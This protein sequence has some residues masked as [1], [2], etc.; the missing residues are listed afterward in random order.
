[1]SKLDFRVGVVFPQTD[2]ENDPIVIRDFAQA[3]EGMGFSSINAYDHILGADPAGRSDRTF[4][5]D[6]ESDFQ[7]P[8]MLF[9]F[10]AGH[11]TRIEL[12]TAVINLPQ[13]QTALFAKQAA[14]LDAYCGGRL[15]L[16]IGIGANPVEY[17]ALGV[18]YAAR[19]KR[20]DDQ[21]VLL[22]RYWTEPTLSYSSPFHEVDQAG[23]SPLPL[24]RPIP[25]WIGGYSPAAMNRAARLGDG[26]MPT[27][28]AAV[29]SERLDQFHAA[30]ADAGRGPRDVGF[31]NHILLGNALGGP[32]RTIDDA[33]ADVEIW[34]KA[35]APG[36]FIST[37]GR[38]MRGADAHLAMFRRIAEDLA[39]T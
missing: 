31:E 37:L 36:V 12:S 32:V 28:P 2:I 38:G 1:M 3:V 7:E 24:Q 21:I 39:L 25:L 6:H 35:G 23:I 4:P 16:G 13:R 34:R 20:L 19:G 10:L 17:Q 26:W 9:A 11:T 18:D 8:L 27:L 14:N 30:L 22:R 15:R 5:F 33:V 29:A